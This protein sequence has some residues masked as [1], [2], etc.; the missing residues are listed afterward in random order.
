VEMLM[1]MRAD[2]DTLSRRETVDVSLVH[3]DSA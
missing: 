3:R 2:P 1:Q